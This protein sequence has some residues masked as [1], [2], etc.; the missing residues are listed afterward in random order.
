V[1]IGSASLRTGLPIGCATT[2]TAHAGLC[3]LVRALAQDAGHQGVTANV[4]SAGM[5]QAD[6]SSYGPLSGSYGTPVGGGSLGRLVTVEEIASLSLY[7][8]CPIAQIVT[9]QTLMADAGTFVFGEL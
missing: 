8:C 7:L 9:G 1:F 2:A 6:V 3:G 4:V 5:T